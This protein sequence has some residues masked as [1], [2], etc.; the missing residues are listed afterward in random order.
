RRRR[1]AALDARPHARTPV[2]ARQAPEDR[3]DPADRRP[4]PLSRR[5][6]GEDVPQCRARSDEDRRIA[7]TRRTARRARARSDLDRARHPR[8]RAAA[9]SPRVLRMMRY[10]LGAACLTAL[11][12]LS[13]AADRP[14]VLVTTDIGGTD[15]DDF[16]SMVHTRS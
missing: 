14:R 16:Q 8:L 11:T 3:R 12:V 15:P 7:R 9:Q 6:D 10:W 13:P 4:L 1:H 2:A 5:A